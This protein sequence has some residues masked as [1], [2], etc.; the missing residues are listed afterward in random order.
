MSRRGSTGAGVA[1]AVSPN[2]P[3][4]SDGPEDAIISPSSGPEAAHGAAQAA[5]P[6]VDE[7]GAEFVANPP[8]QAAL[9][10]TAARKDDGE[11]RRDLQIFGDHLDAAGRDV[12]DHAVT[13]QRPCA[14]LNFGDAPALT[15]F[16]LAAID[17]HPDPQALLDSFS[18][19][20][21]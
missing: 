1:S 16:A 17:K 8:G 6:S 7:L 2:D 14:Q 10:R 9:T 4:M 12:G 3:V 11:F 15:A 20:P 19:P 21:S 13:R 18:F 5:R